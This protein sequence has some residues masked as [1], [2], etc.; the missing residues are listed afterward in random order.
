MTI[1]DKFSVLRVGMPGRHATISN[2]LGDRLRP[3]HDFVVLVQGERR[4]VSVAMT[5]EATPLKNPHDLVRVGDLGLLVL[6]SDS[7]NE[8]SRCRGDGRRDRLARQQLFQRASQVVLLRFVADVPDAILVV[9]PSPIA[10]AAVS[11]D[12]K[13]LRRPLRPQL[14]RHPIADVFEDGKVDLV[15]ACVGGDFGDRILR[16]GVHADETNPLGLKVF[17]QAIQPGTVQL[18]QR[19]LRTQEGDDQDVMAI[20]NRPAD[21]RGRESP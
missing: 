6:L 1:V 5:F 19:A 11:I 16:I 2:D 4:D 7:T 17:R 12:H 8:A 13:H 18:G 14:V 15:K 10:D 20:G 3:T 9:D 21:I